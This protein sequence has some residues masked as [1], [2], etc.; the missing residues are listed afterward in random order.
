M[1]QEAKKTPLEIA[2]NAYD[3]AIKKANDALKSNPV[4]L[5]AFN[6][7]MSD[8]EKSEKDYAKAAASSMYAEY[9]KKQNPIVEI[10]K[11]YSYDTLS[12]KEKRSD[13]KENPHVIA[14][15]PDTRKRQ[16]DLLAFCSVA[17]LDTHWE[18]TASAVN[19]LMCLRTATDLGADVGKIAKSYFLRDKVK[20]IKL[21]KTPTSKNQVCKLLQSVIDEV[22]PSDENGDTPYK[23]NSHDVAYLDDLYGKKSNKNILTIRVS[24]DAFFRRILVDICYRLLT[25]SKYGVDGYKG[26]KDETESK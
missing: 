11:A 19:Q 15:D 26:Y 4:D 5:V 2:K 12:H 17:K 18:L 25:G 7:A 1:A 14:I 6:A 13:D 22:L 23:V 3:V 20:E 24:N 8:L 10:I 16:I 9:A 21:G